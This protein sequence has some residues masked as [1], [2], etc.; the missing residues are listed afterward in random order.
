MS[1]SVMIVLHIAAIGYY[2]HVKKQKLIKPMIRGRRLLAH[3]TATPAG[4]R[5]AKL[6][7]AAPVSELSIA[8]EPIFK[9]QD[10]TPVPNYLAIP[11]P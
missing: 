1:D 2:G 9:A 5:D 3:A 7:V 11:S 10:L 8:A 4:S 6:V